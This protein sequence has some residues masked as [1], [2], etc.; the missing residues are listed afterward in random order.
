MPFNIENQ[1]I[2]QGLKLPLKVEQRHFI[3]KQLIWWCSVSV[4]SKEDYFKISRPKKVASVQFGFWGSGM[5]V[6]GYQY[7]VNP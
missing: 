4:L 2:M 6:I 5:A 7:S 3:Y 1:K